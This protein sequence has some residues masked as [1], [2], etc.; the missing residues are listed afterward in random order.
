MASFSLRLK[1]FFREKLVKFNNVQ[2]YV[3]KER[4]KE[5]SI[6]KW[7]EITIS[8]WREF[9]SMRLSGGFPVDVGNTVTPNELRRWSDVLYHTTLCRKL[10]P[11]VGYPFIVSFLGIN[12]LNSFNQWTKNFKNFAFH[13]LQCDLRRMLFQVSIKIPLGRFQQ[14]LLFFPKSQRALSDQR[15][16]A[17]SG[18]SPRKRQ[19][20]FDASRRPLKD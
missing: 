4:N 15:E 1:S 12:F 20:E 18:V 14:D 5:K 10:V 2:N 8:T 9:S 6:F 17:E 13:L 16:L 11:Y 19:S 3:Q 7:F